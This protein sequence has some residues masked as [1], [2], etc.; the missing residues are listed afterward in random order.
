ME[1]LVGAAFGVDV[2]E[3]REGAGSCVLVE[4]G[5]GLDVGDIG[6]G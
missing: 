3:L 6:S 1:G 2:S 4:L 5:K